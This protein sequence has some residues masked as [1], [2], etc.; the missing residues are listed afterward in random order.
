MEIRIAVCDSDEE[1]SRDIRSMILREEPFATVRIFSSAEELLGVEEHFHIYFLDIRGVGGM[2]I[3]HALRRKQEGMGSR[4]IIIFVT[5]FSEH[6]EEA[7]DVGA[8]HYLLKPIDT[9]KFRHVLHRALEEIHALNGE[10]KYILINIA[11]SKDAQKCTRKILIKDIIY[12]ESNNKRVT[13]H[14]VNGTYEVQGSMKEFEDLLGENFYR[15]HRYY[16]IN[17]AKVSAY[18]QNDIVMENGD[19]IMIAYRKY[20]AFVKAYLSYARGG[21]VVNV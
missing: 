10:E 8:F 14:S 20:P 6:M 16:L 2:E 15:C 9:E 13:L 11:G 19:R 5:G 12:V 17:F 18:N 3:A 7:F 21:G 4:S 1:V